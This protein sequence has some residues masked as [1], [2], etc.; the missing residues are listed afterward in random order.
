MQQIVAKITK[1]V[2]LIKKIRTQ[3]LLIIHI[4]VIIEVPRSRSNR[5]TNTS[6][7][8]KSIQKGVGKNET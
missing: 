2:F 5:N 8:V 4:I 1:A 6:S 7:I 3:H